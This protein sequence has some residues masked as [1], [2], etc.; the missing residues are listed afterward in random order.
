MILGTILASVGGGLLMLFNT[1]TTTAQRIGYQALVGVGIGVGWQQPIV[2]V[3]TV[4]R[5]EDI[6]TTTA[7]I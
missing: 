2:A 7:I 1:K 5:M 4:F 6:P 3:R